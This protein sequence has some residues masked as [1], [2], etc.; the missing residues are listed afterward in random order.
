MSRK[1]TEAELGWVNALFKPHFKGKEILY[2]QIMNSEVVRYED[3]STIWL[4]F[5]VEGNVERYPYNA[6][7]PVSMTQLREGKSPL[8][9][10]LHLVDGVVKEL[11]VLV[12][13][14]TEELDD[15]MINPEKVDYYGL[16]AKII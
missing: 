8:N 6:C 7:M 16:Y 4:E 3:G 9:Y 5:Y 14:F 13:D 11:E 15:S 1:L 12:Y 2:Q 10:L